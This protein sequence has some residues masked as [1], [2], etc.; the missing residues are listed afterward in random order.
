MAAQTGREMSRK[1]EYRREEKEAKARFNRQD[2]KGQQTFLRWD[3][4][5]CAEN[6]FRT[7]KVLLI[8]I[9][10]AWS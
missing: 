8:N 3:I 2:N 1:T 5:L 6:Y 7:F 4:S 9:L 10:R